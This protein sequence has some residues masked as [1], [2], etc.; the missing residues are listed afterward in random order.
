MSNTSSKVAEFTAPGVNNESAAD[1][2]AILDKRMVALIDLHLTLKHIHWNVVGPN[3]I[4]VHEMLDPQVSAVQ[5]MT[6]TIAERIAT[7][8]GVPVGTPQSIVDRREWKDYSLGKGLV[9]D[10]LTALDKVYNG[11]NKDHRKALEQLAELDPVSEDMITGQLA[12]L[13]QFQWFVRAHIE[14]STGEL[15]G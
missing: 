7:M 2:I 1:T 14:S 10:H 4:G 12:E 15:K 13:E 11:V 8:G 5:E 3:F 9:S 6:D